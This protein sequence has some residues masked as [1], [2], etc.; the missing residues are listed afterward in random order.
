[1][2]RTTARRHSVI[3]RIVAILALC[4]L[5]ITPF[6]RTAHADEKTSD[7]ETI[8][9]SGGID[10][11]LMGNDRIWVGTSLSL[12]NTEVKNDLLIAGQSMQV[13]NSQVGGSVRAAG[14]TVELTNVTA[15][16]NITVAGETVTIADSK[17][18]A[19]AMAGRTATFS[20][21]CSSLAIYAG[22][23]YIDGTVE[24][25]VNVG[26]DSVTVGKNARILGTLHVDA[27]NDPVIDSH[28]EVADLD[29]TQAG[30]SEASPQE[31][32]EAVSR[33]VSPFKVVLT[34]AGIV[35]TVIVAVLAEWLFARNT[36]EASRMI[37]TRTGAHIGTG[38]V[39]TLVAPVA[40][41]LLCVLVIT[42]PVAGC[43]TLA[44]F[45]MA[46]AAG[47]FASAS[48]FKLAFPKLGRYKCAL[49]GGAIVGVAEALP[50]LGTLVSIAAYVYLLGYVL[51]SIYLG[52]NMPS[53]WQADD[54]ESCSV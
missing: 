30:G 41:I 43:L 16:E 4:A 53:D 21:T 29:F 46:V 6:A 22:S 44:L 1:M 45:S 35:G 37:R 26:A 9:A 18:N 15:Q 3:L 50:V 14:Q 34:V 32:G 42:L 54:S 33:L 39:G 20:G 49:A 31:A 24:G 48:L 23:V 52:L 28:A 2:T 13:E 7:S 47:G 8:A 5:A 17:A 12:G 11:A 40:I 10:L 51:Q 27:T 25:N 19:V 38:L 36:L